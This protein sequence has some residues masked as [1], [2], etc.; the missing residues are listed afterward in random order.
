MA[1]AALIRGF[2]KLFKYLATR[3]VRVP[4]GFNPRTGK[5]MPK[6]TGITRRGQTKTLK[7][8]QRILKKEGGGTTFLKGSAK[9]G[10]TRGQKGA[11]YG[12]GGAAIIAGATYKPPSGPPT[13]GQKQM[14]AVG[15]VPKWHGD[16]A[17]FSPSGYH[18]FKKGSRSATQF[19]KSYKLAKKTGAKEFT[20]GLTGKKYK[21]SP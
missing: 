14:S 8:G 12:A 6:G 7:G 9:L 13:A 11:A 20:W 2:S 3:N 21:V 5:M 19:S 1:S 18:T 4:G 17:K 10:M 15:K 16:V